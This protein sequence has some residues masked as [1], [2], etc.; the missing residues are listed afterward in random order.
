MPLEHLGFI[1]CP[2]L[3]CQKDILFEWEVLLWANYSME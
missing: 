3:D 2:L 1:R